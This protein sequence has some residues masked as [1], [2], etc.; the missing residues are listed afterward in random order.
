MINISYTMH[1]LFWIISN[2]KAFNNHYLIKKT[3]ILQSKLI[4]YHK[5]N[6]N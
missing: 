3:Q 2:I 1:Q 5:A 4:N 6:N